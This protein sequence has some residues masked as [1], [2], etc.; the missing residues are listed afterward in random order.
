[1]S[2]FGEKTEERWISVQGVQILDQSIEQP[3]YPKEKEM[4]MQLVV[5]LSGSG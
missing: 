3:K 2:L 4:D 5:E 1:M